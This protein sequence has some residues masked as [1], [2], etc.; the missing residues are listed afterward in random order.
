MGQTTVEEVDFTDPM[1]L[2]EVAAIFRVEPPTVARWA[3]EGRLASTR[4]GRQ[5]RFSRAQVNALLRGE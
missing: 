4:E 3:R 2:S 1:P 5:W